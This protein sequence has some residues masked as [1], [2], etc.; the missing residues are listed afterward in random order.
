MVK[1]ETMFTPWRAYGNE[2]SQ[3][4]DRILKL[5]RVNLLL[6]SSTIQCF[7]MSQVYCRS[8]TFC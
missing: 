8:F 3:T 5:L 6:K 1:A 4:I 7:R 2:I